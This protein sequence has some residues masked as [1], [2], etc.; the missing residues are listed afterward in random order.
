MLFWLSLSA[1]A[2]FYD[3]DSPSA[4]VGQ[5]VNT[6]GL[7]LGASLADPDRNFVMSLSNRRGWMVAPLTSAFARV[8]TTAR[9]GTDRHLTAHGDLGLSIDVTVAEIY[10]FAGAGA[11]T[12]RALP[13]GL[14][15]YRQVGAGAVL[16]RGIGDEQAPN[17]DARLTFTVEARRAWWTDTPHTMVL[18][19]IGVFVQSPREAE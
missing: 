10:G 14:N 6:S 12:G 4:T 3:G 5:R 8:G 7:M 11:S 9:L 19:A 2:G 15:L 18:G 1:L 17:S 13:S 16:R